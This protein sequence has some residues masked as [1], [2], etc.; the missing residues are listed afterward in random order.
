MKQT[1]ALLVSSCC[2]KHLIFLH[3]PLLRSPPEFLHQLGILYTSSASTASTFL[4]LWFDFLK[5]FESFSPPSP[6][7]MQMT[8]QIL[9]L[10]N[11]LQTF[12][13]LNRISPQDFKSVPGGLNVPDC[14]YSDII[15]KG[16]FCMRSLQ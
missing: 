14:P 4:H 5:D 10:I 1:Q 16:A 2:Q 11:L 9:V 12:N 15:L 13:S 8:L 3:H 6:V 7:P